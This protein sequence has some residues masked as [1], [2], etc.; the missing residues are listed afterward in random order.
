MHPPSFSTVFSDSPDLVLLVERA[1][2]KSEETKGA[3][4]DIL[5]RG[6][7]IV[8][9]GNV[10]AESVKSIAERVALSVPGVDEVENRIQVENVI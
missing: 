3:A 7:H 4:L 2:A 10:P 8:L 5:A 1:L 9:M 6:G